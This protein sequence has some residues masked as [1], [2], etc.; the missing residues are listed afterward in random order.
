MNRRH[1]MMSFLLAAVAGMCAANVS[2]GETKAGRPNVLLMICDDLNDWALHLKGHP[3]AI[4][5]NMDR[6]RDMGVSFSNAH[7]AVP[8]CGP[9]RLSTFSGLYPQT[10]GNCNL[11]RWKG[12]PALK[13]CAPLPLHFRNNGYHSYGTGKL[14]HEGA[15]GD[16]YTK[17]GIGPDYGP[18][19]WT[20]KGRPLNT[21]HPAQIAAWKAHLDVK[22]HRDLNYGPLSNV[23]KWKRGQGVNGW[24]NTNGK[25]FKYVNEQK[26][27]R[28]P[29]EVSADW[30]I[31]IL[32][33]KQNRPFYLAV[34]FIRPHSPF[35]APKKFF[36]MYPLNKIQL[37]PYKKGDLDDCADV[38]RKRWQ[39][40]YQ[41]HN[42]LVK[43][44]G[45][46]AL[47]EWVQ[48]YLACVSFVDHEIGRVLDALE[49]S[50]HGKNT[51]IVLTGDNGYHGGE[52]NCVQKYHLWEESTRVPLYIHVP[53]SKS[54]GKQCDTPVSLIDLYP[55]LVDL[56]G[57][58]QPKN[59]SGMSLDGHS[60]RPLLEDPA[61]G[62]WTGPPVALMAIQDKRGG[63]HFSVR[64]KEYRYTLCFNGEEELYDHDKDPNEWT[65]LAKSKKHGAAKRKLRSELVG[66]LKASKVPKG[67]PIGK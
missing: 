52:K 56:C 1:F 62:R 40:G 30:A 55:T 65:N 60:L 63:P 4:T 59:R 33:Q 12:A 15:G 25:P 8:V 67:F 28:L 5:P 32:K 42:A 51:I 31:D 26:R 45:E 48:S 23:P 57:L 41:K 36:D 2:G 3:E 16:F 7:V 38:L 21:A 53:G 20:G 34:G 47:K 37:P 9:S 18:W 29:D 46:K 11:W 54:R 10:M 44:G 49:K 14:L 35:Y 17:Y 50:P 43:S 61:R 66:L 27:D 39:L 24:F 6:L 64:S 22:I 13:G 19:P 58:P